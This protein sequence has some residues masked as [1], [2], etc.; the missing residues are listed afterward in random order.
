LFPGWCF[1]ES[2]D[3]F[4]AG[5]LVCIAPNCECLEGKCIGEKEYI[6]YFLL[7]G[8]ALLDNLPPAAVLSDCQQGETTSSQLNIS[9]ATST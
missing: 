8:N 5:A 9:G 1:W 2:R 4:L 6:G 7:A 3:N